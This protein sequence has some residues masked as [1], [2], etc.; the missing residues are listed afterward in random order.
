MLLFLLAIITGTDILLSV[1]L[2]ASSTSVPSTVNPHWYQ[3]KLWQISCSGHHNSSLAVLPCLCHRSYPIPVWPTL[4]LMHTLQQNTGRQLHAGIHTQS[5]HH[6]QLTITV[7]YLSPPTSC[8]GQLFIPQYD[9]SKHTYTQ[10]DHA[11]PHNQLG[12][13]Y[14]ILA[15]LFFTLSSAVSVSASLLFF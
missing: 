1:K 4:I 8:C 2:H 14:G 3:I 15:F 6:F 9:V 11:V 10:T 7:L 13:L 12:H 5:K